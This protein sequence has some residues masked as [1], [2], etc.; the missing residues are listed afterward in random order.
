MSQILPIGY[1]KYQV[2][3]CMYNVW[4]RFSNVSDKLKFMTCADDMKM[5]F[6]LEH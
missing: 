4:Q 6:N 1:H 3:Q 2:W 5:Y